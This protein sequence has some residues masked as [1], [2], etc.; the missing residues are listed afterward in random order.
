MGLGILSSV[1]RHAITSDLDMLDFR[2]LAVA[3]TTLVYL[4]KQ[5]SY[6][7][8]F[9]PYLFNILVNS[10]VCIG[11]TTASTFLP[12]P[13]YMLI[14]ITLALVFYSYSNFRWTLPK[15]VEAYLTEE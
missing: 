13:E 2:V 5:I 8:A 4:G 15:N 6:F 14:G 7:V 9:P 3:G 10:T 11:V 12:R 1:I